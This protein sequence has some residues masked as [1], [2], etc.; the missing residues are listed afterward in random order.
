M[1]VRIGKHE[2]TSRIHSLARLNCK[3]KDIVCTL[4]TIFSLAPFFRQAAAF[5]FA[6]PL[7]TYSYTYI[8][9]SLQSVRVAYCSF[10]YWSLAAWKFLC[11]HSH[12]FTVA[13]KK[14]VKWR[15][16]SGQNRIAFPSFALC[17]C[18]TYRNFMCGKW[19]EIQILLYA[20]YCFR[21]DTARMAKVLHI[22]V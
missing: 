13:H 18:A 9:K 15:T 5:W 21:D 1:A 19:K 4:F 14:D 6:F 20:F 2:M 16:A 8:Q 11:V 3:Q 17:C 7:A 12:F 22:I 10:A